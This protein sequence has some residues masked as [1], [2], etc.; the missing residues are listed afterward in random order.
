M[1][2]NINIL[3]RSLLEPS[4]NLRL[5]QSSTFQQYIDPKPTD[6][7]ILHYFNENQVKIQEWSSQDLSQT[8]NLW[9]DLKEGWTQTTPKSRLD[10]PISWQQTCWWNCCLRWSHTWL[11]FREATNA[12]I[13]FTK[14]TSKNVFLN[15]DTKATK[16]KGWH[17]IFW[18]IPVHVSLQFSTELFSSDSP[19]RV[20]QQKICEQ[21]VYEDLGC[22]GSFSEK[23]TVYKKL[24]CGIR[25]IWGLEHNTICMCNGISYISKTKG[26]LI[27]Y[28][29]F[30]LIP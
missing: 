12:K 10:G 28:K 29:T 11:S 5:G 3:E 16:Q 13:F 18:Q 6:Q 22:H 23:N 4:R 8:K 27:I 21:K 20:F 26:S 15:F 1:N 17:F 9:L 7:A 30:S 25:G 24:N 14:Q 2:Q 19:K